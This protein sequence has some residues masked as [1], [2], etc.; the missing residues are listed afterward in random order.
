MAPVAMSPGMADWTAANPEAAAA[1][2]ATVPLGRIGNCEAD[3]G[4]GVAMLCSPMAGFLTGAT[5]PLDG[6]L[7]NF[8]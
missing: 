5:I 6:G 8:D 4:E 3:I 1:Y 2:V 7:A